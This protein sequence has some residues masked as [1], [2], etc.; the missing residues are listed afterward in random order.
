M[1]SKVLQPRNN[2]VT[3]FPTYRPL[4]LGFFEINPDA[5]GTTKAS[6]YALKKTH[7]PYRKQLI[8]P[9]L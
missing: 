5:D 1:I 9:N 2:W 4:R 6:L 7:L 3:A 8:Q